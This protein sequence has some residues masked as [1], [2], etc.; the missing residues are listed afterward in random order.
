M[1]EVTARYHA[2][3]SPVTCREEAQFLFDSIK[4]RKAASSFLRFLE[5]IRLLPLGRP[6]VL[7]LGRLKFDEILSNEFLTLR[8]RERSKAWRQV[9][10]PNVFRGHDPRG[11]RKFL[12]AARDP[13][14]LRRLLLQEAGFPSPETFSLSTL[15]RLYESLPA[16]THSPLLI[17]ICNFRGTVVRW[18]AKNL[19]EG[20]DIVAAGADLP[21]ERDHHRNR[22]N[23]RTNRVRKAIR[24]FRTAIRHASD[25]G[26]P[27]ALPHYV[28]PHLEGLSSEEAQAYH[29]IKEMVAIK[30][31]TGVPR[32]HDALSKYLHDAIDLLEAEQTGSS[33]RPTKPR[34]HVQRLIQSA[35]KRL[36]QPSGCGAIKAGH[37]TRKVQL[38]LVPLR[39]LESLVLRNLPDPLDL[40]LALG[41]LLVII[42]LSTGRRASDFADTTVGHFS[43]FSNLLDLTILQTKTASVT[44]IQLPLHRLIPPSL[45]PYAAQ[46]INAL[47]TAYAT[48]T[49]LYEVLTGKKRRIGSGKSKAA[50]C[51]SSA[52]SESLDDEITRTHTFRYAFGTWAPVAAILAWQPDLCSHPRIQPWVEGSAF[53]GPEMLAEWRHLTGSATADPFIT[54]SRILGHTS[55]GELLHSYCT[56]WVIQL[57]IAA[58]NAAKA[59]EIVF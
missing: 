34:I 18:P 50:H 40:P 44:R 17:R 4:S 13:K 39:F 56:S 10:V 2:F 9:L 29:V 41:R 53:F 23:R 11:I 24:G 26:D 46:V 22:R 7:A 1:A 45:R 57:Q 54:V 35:R 15:G 43:L 32:S 36:G 49:T 33:L 55:S 38:N 31:E 12:K 30:N 25:H 3:S 21:S 5:K 16:E 58:I 27:D 37:V 6:G 52:E 42:A 48:E 14:V 8:R 19:P 51:I 20:G 28:F 59:L 47:A